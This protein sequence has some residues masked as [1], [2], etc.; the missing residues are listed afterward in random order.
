V[1]INDAARRAGDSPY[2]PRL[3]RMGRPGF[4]DVTNPA[5]DSSK[6]KQRPTS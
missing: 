4:E 2:F 1:H 5:E 6:P 3:V